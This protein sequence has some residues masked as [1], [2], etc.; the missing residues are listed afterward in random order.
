MKNN[1]IL[2]VFMALF[3]PFIILM[4]GVR[5]MMNP[6]FA[7]FEYDRAGFPLDPYGMD[8]IERKQRAGYAIRYLTN[9][10]SID[11]LGN[12]QNFQGEKIFT[13]SE[14][15]HMV[16]VKEV[17]Q[18]SLLAWYIV[19]GLSVAILGWFLIMGQWSSLRQAFQAGGWVT[20]GLIGAL[21][22]FLLVSF[23]TLFER[24]H[25]LFFA[26]GTWLFDESST[27]IRL[28]PFVFWRD[29]FALVLIFA[30]VVGILLVVITHKRK[31]K[32]AA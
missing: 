29:A 13:E 7:E 30:L 16:D 8:T 22:I 15:S 19:M 27:L 11:Y 32:T 5:L 23:D 12:L 26:E 28:F 4:G 21:L 2:V 3:I 9:S 1:K 20:L 10:E 6:A 14:L 17:V 18:S 25:Q 24:F 31:P